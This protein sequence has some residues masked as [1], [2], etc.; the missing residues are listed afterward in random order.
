MEK[1]IIKCIPTKQFQAIR[2]G[3]FPFDPN[4]LSFDTIGVYFGFDNHCANFA[5]LLELTA[6]VKNEYPDLTDDLVRVCYIT[7]DQSECHANQIM[8]HAYVPSD[9]VRRDIEDYIIL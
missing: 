2:D 5:Q 1:Q 4:G 6:A 9:I 7:Q 8:L 3:E